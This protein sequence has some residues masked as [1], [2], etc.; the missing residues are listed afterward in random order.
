MKQT[1]I[2]IRIIFLLL[3][4]GASYG[5]C[6]LAE[7][8]DSGLFAMRFYAMIFGVVLA[9]LV[10][11]FDIYFK[12]FSIR[13]LTA[14]IF[15]LFVG[16]GVSTF[17]GMSPLFEGT[18]NGTMRLVRLGLYFVFMYMGAVMALRGKDDFNLI[19]PYVK[20]ERR[21]IDVPIA[22]VDSSILI[23]G[24]VVGIVE[25]KFLG[26]SVIVPSFVLE[27]ILRMADSKDAARQ[28]RGRKGLD[29]LARL[30]NLRH[31]DLHMH[32]TTPAKGSSLEDNLITLCRTLHAKLMTLDYNL[33]KVAELHNVEHLNLNS[34][35]R[36][37]SSEVV[38]GE[39]LDVELVKP[40]KEQGQ[41]VGF[42]VD[43]TMVVVTG[44]HRSLGKQV[45]VAVDSIM[46]TT[47]G[48]MVFASI[49]KD[50][51]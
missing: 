19:I 46:R 1:I 13:G 45:T 23:D 6:Y 2:A 16:W 32:E 28:Q 22:V 15:G 25:A 33:A 26:H 39:L 42:L 12:G 11:L 48:R 51:A 41:A 37:L 7:G 10:I 43:G 30:K 47:A 35:A 49:V 4:A 9:V 36:A 38:V 31:L 34:L 21:G 18:D 8:T 40:G 50:E 20:F 27:E 29:T 5:I 44:G 14:M 24:R 17:L 3:A